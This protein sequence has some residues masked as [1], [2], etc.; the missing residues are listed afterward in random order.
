MIKKDFEITIAS[1]P[2]RE[3]LVA[4]IFYK[5]VEWIE[6]SAE[7]PNQFVVV[8]CNN[9]KGDYW[10]FPYEEAMKVLQEAKNRLAKYQRTPEE[11]AEYDAMKKEQENWNPTPEETAE[12]ERKMEE[13]RKK[14]YG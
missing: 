5:N 14:Y 12:Y 9:D 4:E 6:I 11:Q 3:N 13:Q 8:F 2:D 1:L 10:E 7:I